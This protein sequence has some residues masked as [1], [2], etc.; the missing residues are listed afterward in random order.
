LAHMPAEEYAC[1]R[2]P[3][4]QTR[5]GMMGLY[6]VAVPVAL[7][8]AVFSTTGA[9]SPLPALTTTRAPMKIAGLDACGA[10]KCNRSLRALDDL[11]DR[12]VA[13][14][15]NGTGPSGGGTRKANVASAVTSSLGQ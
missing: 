5:E 13:W 14:S 11:C 7:C 4:E 1:R 8:F 3:P 12:G 15:T 10:E 6:R 2:S 9:A